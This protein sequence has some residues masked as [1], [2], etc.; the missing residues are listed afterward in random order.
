LID[1]IHKNVVSLGYLGLDGCNSI[2]I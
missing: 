2:F 1:F